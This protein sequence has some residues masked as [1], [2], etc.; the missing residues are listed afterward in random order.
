MCVCADDGADGCCVEPELLPW[1][2]PPLLVSLAVAAALPD[3]V[4]RTVSLSAGVVSCSIGPAEA[5][6]ASAEGAAGA[7]SAGVGG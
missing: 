6:G 5:G 4:V 7:S 3:D 1:L 2:L